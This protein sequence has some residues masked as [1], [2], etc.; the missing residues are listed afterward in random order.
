MVVATLVLVGSFS[1]A[2][3]GSSCCTP[4]CNYEL[5]FGK[6]G[7]KAIS[8]WE[9]NLW[10]LH[11]AA[12]LRY[13]IKTRLKCCLWNAA[14]GLAKLVVLHGWATPFLTVLFFK[15]LVD[16]LL[17]LWIWTR[18]CRR[19]RQG[20]KREYG[21]IMLSLLFWKNRILRWYSSSV[22]WY[23][24]PWEQPNFPPIQAT[25]VKKA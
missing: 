3:R 10:N 14:Y 4:P 1:A 23:I 12:F 21:K 15:V 6:L 8:K 22:P 20:A 17:T 11:P 13:L 7:R 18:L 24:R 9:K 25:Q 16:L 19:I 2:R 5:W